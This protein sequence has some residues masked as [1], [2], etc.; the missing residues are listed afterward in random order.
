MNR[1]FDFTLRLLDGIRGGDEA[2][3]ARAIED[4]SRSRRYLAPLAYAVGGVAMLLGGVRPLFSNWRLTLIQ[5][6]PAISS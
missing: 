4:L 3:I 5:V 2:E 1:A 6:L